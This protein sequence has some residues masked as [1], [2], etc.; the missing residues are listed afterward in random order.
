MNYINKNPLK[1]ISVG[2]INPK[3]LYEWKATILIDEEDS[4]YKGG[5]FN[6]NILFP[7]DYPFKP[8][9]IRFTTKIYHC[10]FSIDG[11]IWE[12]NPYD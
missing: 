9:K 3:N 11:L 4:P 2:L 6:L 12:I 5:R 8:P 7:A 10:N 1:N